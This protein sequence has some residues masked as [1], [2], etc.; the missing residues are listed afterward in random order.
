MK[1][2]FVGLGQR[3]A[4]RMYADRPNPQLPH[5]QRHGCEPIEGRSR[6]DRLGLVSNNLFNSAFLNV[7][8]FAATRC[9]RRPALKCYLEGAVMAQTAALPVLSG[10]PD[11]RKKFGGSDVG[12]ARG[13]KCREGA[14]RWGEHGGP[15][16]GAQARHQPSAAR[17]QDRHGVPLPPM[18]Q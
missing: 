17:G 5:G 15:R 12:T 4:I 11:T 6:S 10:L 18:P 1:V 3:A 16:R 13:I 9:N 2:G 14:K 8:L 7:D